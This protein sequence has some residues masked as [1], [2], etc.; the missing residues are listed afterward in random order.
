M[1]AGPE[2]G[3]LHHLLLGTS[4]KVWRLQHGSEDGKL[5]VLLLLLMMIKLGD[6][7]T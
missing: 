5:V 6:P 4:H 1:V 2:Y 7:V 3:A